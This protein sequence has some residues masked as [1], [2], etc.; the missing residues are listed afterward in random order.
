MNKLTI[1]S[2]AP[3]FELPATNDKKIKLSD[4]K[5]QNVVLYFYPKDNTPGCTLEGQSFRD[6]YQKFTE[7]NTVILGISRD[8]LKLHCK[9]KKEQNFP[10]ELLA[11]C[12]ETVCE[13]YD[14]LKDKNMFGKKVRG[15]ERSTFLIDDKGLLR[16]EWRK[17]KVEDHTEA[18]LQAIKAL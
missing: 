13:L 4:L 6:H 18:V 15:I 8:D 5:G 1:N 7:L 17:V 16:T 11:D 2:P 14:V 10:F 9:F 12:N 3:D